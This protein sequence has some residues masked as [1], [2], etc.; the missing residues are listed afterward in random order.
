MDRKDYWDKK[1]AEYWKSVTE[2]AELGGTADSSIK[3]LSGHDYKTPNTEVFTS[4]FDRLQYSDKD[5]LLDYGCGLGRFYPYFSSKCIYYGIDI[6]KAMIEE[7]IKKFP[8]DA[9]R[10]IVAEGENLPFEDS[11]F[12]RII[13]NG[14]FDACYQEQALK[15]MLRV[16][17]VGG[18]IL[19]SGKNAEYF[20][21][22]EEAYVAEVNAAKKGHPNYFTDLHEMLSQIS[23]CCDVI[24][25]RYALR[26]GDFGKGL[27]VYELPN[28][29]YEWQIIIKKQQNI[30]FDFAKFSDSHSKVWKRKNEPLI[31]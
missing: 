27:F 4:F 5:K 30:I 26:R 14:V 25:E 31:Q 29:F 16:C 18:C 15:E 28:V 24:D 12:S 2:E 3:K 19:I 1:Y 23:K 13:C 6:S 9:G 11:F 20:Q 8:A 21:D 17:E 22:D 7:C 10:F